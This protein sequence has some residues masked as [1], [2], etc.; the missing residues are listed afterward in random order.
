MQ[1]LFDE[2][3]LDIPDRALCIVPMIAAAFAL[4]V[5]AF[6][7]PASYR[8]CRLKQL[9]ECKTTS[10][11]VMNAGFQSA[12]KSFAG[13]VP[14]KFVRGVKTPLWEEIIE[15]LH[16]PPDPPIR[17]SDGSYLFTAC[18]AHYC[19]NKGAVILSPRGEIVAAAMFTSEGADPWNPDLP[20]RLALDIFVSTSPA[21][22]LR[23]RPMDEWIAQSEANWRSVLADEHSP[24]EG[25]NVRIWLVQPKTRSMHLLAKRSW[26]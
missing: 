8:E 18:Q 12:V 23:E 14:T 2:F 21:R 15:V 13:S 1:S 6:E 9:T 16:G 10:Y 19:P 5:S 20:S 7:L 3:C 25:S 24:I 17:F 22:I 26:R 4:M 11:L